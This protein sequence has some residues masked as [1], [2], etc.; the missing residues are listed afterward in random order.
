MNLTTSPGNAIIHCRVSNK[1][2]FVELRTVEEANNCLSLTGIPFMGNMLKVGRPTKYTGPPVAAST[3]QQLTGQAQGGQMIDPTTKVYRELFVGNTTDDMNEVELQE[4]LSAAMLRVG[5]TTAEGSPILSTRL[6][7]KFA[8]VELRSIEETN[9][10]LNLN[11]IPYMGQNLRVGRPSKYNGPPVPHLDWNEL[12]TKFVNGIR[13]VVAGSSV[14]SFCD[15]GE[16]QPAL[17]GGGAVTKV[18][19]LSNM[20]TEAELENMEDYNEIVEDTTAEC[21]K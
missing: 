21:S 2:A 17:Q 7:G 3:W 8:F 15:S 11:G 18:I 12:L 1:F 9:N 6:S 14:S 4:F 10:M 20:V 5:L 19:R 13:N 16:L